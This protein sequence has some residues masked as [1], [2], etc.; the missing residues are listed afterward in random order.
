MEDYNSKEKKVIQYRLVRHKWPDE[1]KA[2]RDKRRK[3]VAVVLACIGCFL[4][5]FLLNGYTEQSSR[6]SSFAKLDEV[7]DIMLHD[8]YFG[9]EDENLQ[10]T[11]INN[12]INGLMNNKVDPHT[13]YMSAD[14]SEQFITSLQGNFVGIGIQYYAVDEETAMVD[15]VFKGSGAEAGGMMQGDI[16]IKV[17][18]KDCAGLSLDEISAMIKGEEGTTVNISVLRENE[19]KEL[20]ITRSVVNDSVYGYEK[21]NAGILEINSFAETSGAE[22]Y[23]YLSYFKE[24]GLQN[25]V[26][27]LRDN[28]GGYVIAAMQIGSYLVPEGS[29]IY[30]EQTKAGN[31]SEQVAYANY[32]KFTFDKIVI[33]INEDTASASEVL[34]SCLSEQMDNVEIV[35]KKS[36][37]KGT[38]QL[39]VAFADGSSIKYTVAEWLSPL[40]HHINGVGITPDHIVELDPAV[41]TGILSLE[42]GVTYAQDSVSPYAK[43]VQIYLKFLGYSVDRVDEYFSPSS[44]IALQQ[45]QSDHNLVANGEINEESINSLLSSCSLKW[46]K[47]KDSL[48]KQMI[49]ALSLF[50]R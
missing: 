23:K 31:I 15:R 14:E 18:G 34:T 26:I 41:T 25:L 10:D 16:I 35:G 24:K 48:D 28:G 36:Y 29:I 38:V 21:A 49:K 11:L 39:P 50:E 45:Y 1:I 32:E 40:E 12:A 27:D 2:E 13:M 5:G 22:S 30:K 33:L 7:Y 17:D 19:E 9:K 43:P 4:A 46:H 42:D 6:S 37:G 8:W 44:A 3:R 47:E 20:I